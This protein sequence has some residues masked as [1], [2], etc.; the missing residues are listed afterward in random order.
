LEQNTQAHHGPTY[1]FRTL[2]F[3]SGE[4]VVVT[5]AASGIG[6]ATALTAA[7]S[8][9]TVAVWDLDLGGAR[10]TAA[11]IEK[12]GG[13]AIAVKVDIDRDA[14]V[15]A[16]WEQTLPLGPCRYLVNNAGPESASK[17]PFED[18]LRIAVGGLK[19]VTSTWLEKQRDVAASMVNMASV[20]GNFLAVGN[21][22]F[23]PAAKGAIAALTRQ[24]AFKFKGRPRANA[25]APGF[26][27]T[28][29]TIPYLDNPA[30]AAT[31][32]RI[33]SGRF[34][35]PEDI[36]SAVLFLLSPAADYINGVLLPV[37]GGWVISG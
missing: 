15:Q 18:G 17:M 30:R 9:L 25:V 26:T 1:D 28:P 2:G 8:G 11:E 12:A 29:R 37:D 19:R 21:A 20:S 4:A 3:K 6:R 36:A 24:Y 27:L 16:A 13:R 14:D 7:K 23:Y 10:E 22:E 32:K 31:I 33:P 35:H 34:G 5:G